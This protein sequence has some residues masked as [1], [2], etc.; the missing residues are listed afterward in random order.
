MDFKVAVAAPADVSVAVEVWRAA[1]TARGLPRTVQRVQRVVEKLQAVDA[2]VVLG[3]TGLRVTAVALAEPGRA[4]DCSGEVVPGC[5]HVSMVFVH[6]DLWGQ[7]LGSTLMAGLHANTDRLG[8]V[9][10]SLGRASPTRGHCASTSNAATGP[11]DVQPRCGQVTRSC[12]WSAA[13]DCVTS[14]PARRTS[15]GLLRSE[16]LARPRAARSQQVG[17][18]L[19]LWVPVGCST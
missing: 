10:T 19:S 5:G 2:S 7:G 1:N 4:D 15:S 11:P 3:R 9:R 16:A 8:W 12:N 18:Y 6:P 14:R 17:T 13:G